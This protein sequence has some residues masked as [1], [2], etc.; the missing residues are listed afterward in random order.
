LLWRSF[1][2]SSLC[3]ESGEC[4]DLLRL[5]SSFVSKVSVPWKLTKRAQGTIISPC[6]RRAWL[7]SSSLR[8]ADPGNVELLTGAE[9]NAASAPAAPR[10]ASDVF[11]SYPSPDLSV[12][13][14]I[15]E[16]LERAG[17]KCVGGRI[18]R[19]QFDPTSHGGR[20]NRSAA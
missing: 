12:A 20:I 15:C 7:A 9:A 10:G 14:R 2:V 5:R 19:I 18:Q 17:V 11:F 16:A 8:P 3:G 4:H 6:S 1:S 13:E